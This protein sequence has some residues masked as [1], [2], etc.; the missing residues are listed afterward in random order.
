VGLVGLI[1]PPREGVKEAVKVCKRAGISVIMITGDHPITAQAIANQIGITGRVLKGS[2]LDALN[3]ESLADLIPFPT[4]FARVTPNHKLLIVEALKRQKNVVSM[5]G[6]GVNDAPAIKRADIGIAMGITGTDLAK[7]ASSLVL[8][9]DNFCTILIAVQEGRRIRDNIVRFLVYLLACNSAEIWTV[10]VA[11][12]AGWEMPLSAVNIL[13]ANIVADIP[14]SLAL[15]MEPG[16][17][18]SMESAPRSLDQPILNR[19]EIFLILFNGFVISAGTLL[20]F[21][22]DL[23]LFKQELIFARSN[24]FF[25]LTSSQI[26]LVFTCKSLHR[27]LFDRF[28]VTPWMLLSL[29]VSFGLLLIGHYVPWFNE[30]VLQLE[31]VSWRAWLGTVIVSV[32]LLVMSEVIKIF[33]RKRRRKPSEI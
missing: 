20:T 1:D 14:P 16:E 12:L 19:Y 31:P 18:D 33:K 13:W 27:S 8:T 26:L 5:T 4:V 17:P 9:D 29:L 24:S 28:K 6:D 30:R 25:V 21:K 15:G 3:E 10:L 23:T 2:E 32:T 11:V 7:Q 22:L